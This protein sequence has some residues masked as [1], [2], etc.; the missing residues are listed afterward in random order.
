MSQGCGP[1][2]AALSSS[3]PWEFPLAIPPSDQL[4]NLLPSPVPGNLDRVFESSHR[5]GFL[6]KN[7]FPPSQAQKLEHPTETSGQRRPIWDVKVPGSLSFFFQVSLLFLKP[8]CNLF[9]NQTCVN[10]P[11]HFQVLTQ[12]KNWFKQMMRMRLICRTQKSRT[13]ADLVS[14]QPA[15]IV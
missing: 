6:L 8:H 11:M 1:A 10:I 7:F 9:L 14:D 2:G 5:P 4:T 3:I 12:L 13:V 15:K